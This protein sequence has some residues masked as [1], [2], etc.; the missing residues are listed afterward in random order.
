MTV[1]GNQFQEFMA[2][3][4]GCSDD[5]GDMEEAWNQVFRTEKNEQP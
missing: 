2:E 5:E 3:R 4:R 1:D